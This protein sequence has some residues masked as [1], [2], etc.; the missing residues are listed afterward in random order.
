MSD[1]SA[2]PARRPLS[3]PFSHPDAAVDQ[4][5]GE[6]LLPVERSPFSAPAPVASDAGSD[7]VHAR[8]GRRRL[9]PGGL[10]AQTPA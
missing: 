4:P 7:Q 6:R 9:G 2:R 1:Q 8:G 3:Q 5:V 10:A